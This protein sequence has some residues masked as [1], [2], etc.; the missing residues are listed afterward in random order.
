LDVIR[1]IDGLPRTTAAQVLGK[2]VLR[3][4]TS[5]RV[6]YR[7]AS[8]ARSKLEWSERDE[9]HRRYSREDSGE[10]VGR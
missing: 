10:R 8:R 6:N 5:I 7:E 3:S 2:Q 9:R 4:A 1:M